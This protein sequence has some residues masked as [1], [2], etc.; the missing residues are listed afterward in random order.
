MLKLLSVSG[1]GELGMAESSGNVVLK[2]ITDQN[3]N[4]IHVESVYCDKDSEHC[5]DN[6]TKSLIFYTHPGLAV[7][8]MFSPLSC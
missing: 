1:G 7:F 6:I 4:S 5:K 2:E 3:K 8:N